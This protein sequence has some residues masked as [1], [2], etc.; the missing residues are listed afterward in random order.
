MTVEHIPKVLSPSGSIDSAPNYFGVLVS[1]DVSYIVCR[2]L[3]T[4]RL[5]VD[6]CRC[7]LLRKK[8]ESLSE[9]LLIVVIRQY[10]L[11]Q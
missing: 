7:L 1:F 8:P 4:L 11:S 2:C 9:T 3:C 5:C 6:I 10:R